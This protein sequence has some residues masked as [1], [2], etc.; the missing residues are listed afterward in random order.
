M[1]VGQNDSLPCSGMRRITKPEYFGEDANIEYTSYCDELR[2]SELN[3]AVVDSRC[4]D[5]NLRTRECSSRY[6]AS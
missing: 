6:S 1:R 4:T 5:D 2:A 3:G